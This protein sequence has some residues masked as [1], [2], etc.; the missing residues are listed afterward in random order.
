MDYFEV[1][2]LQLKEAVIEANNFIDRAITLLN[3]MEEEL[4]AQYP[5]ESGAMKRS[6]MELSQKLVKLRKSP[7]WD[8]RCGGK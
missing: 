5:R 3:R 2:K 8:V 4:I 6:S 7:F 1:R